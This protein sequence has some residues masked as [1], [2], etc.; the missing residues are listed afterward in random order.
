MRLLG[1]LFA[2]ASCLSLAGPA[3]AQTAATSARIETAALRL[4]DPDPY[5]VAAVLQPIR[6]LKMV[7]PMDGKI[8]SVEARLGE[9]VRQWQDL[10]QFDPTEAQAG[11]RIAEAGLKQKPEEA[12]AARVEIARAHL[13]R[14]TVRAPFTARVAEVAAYPGQFVLKGTT[15][16]ELIDTS[17]L[18]VVVPVDRRKVAI[19]TT[20]NVPVE[21]QE[22][23]GKVQAILPLPEDLRILRELA[24]PF[25]AATVIL[26]NPK[27]QLDAGLRARPVGVPTTPIANIAK[28]ALRA[29]DLRGPSASMVQVIRNEYVTNIPVQVL[30]GL[31]P[32][33][34]QVSGLFRP[35]DA[36]IVGASVPMV[37]GTLVRFHEGP[38][39]R[40]IEATSPDPSHGGL[41]AG[42]TPPG[43]AHPYNTG[44]A[45]RPGSVNTRP[46]FSR[47]QPTQPAGGQTPF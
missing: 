23:A 27:G 1:T 22:F 41:E 8:R 39:A 7:A 17:S 2:C 47:P 4:I 26:P 24:P 6:R 25:A 10:V 13:D 35:N 32:D 5:Q 14:C 34:V 46:T 33:R 44:A 45:R 38:S 31:G 42:L 16:V 3:M 12:A 18:E 21:E 20:I 9:S 37:P 36:L 29:D 40:G 19:G 11:L 43:G 30:G 28:R 15:L